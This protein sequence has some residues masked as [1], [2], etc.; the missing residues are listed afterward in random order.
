MTQNPAWFVDANVF[1]GGG[2]KAQVRVSEQ[3]D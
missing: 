3:R 2:F 1:G